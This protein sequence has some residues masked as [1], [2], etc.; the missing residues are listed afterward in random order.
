[1]NLSCQQSPP[2]TTIGKNNLVSDL[3]WVAIKSGINCSISYTYTADYVIVSTQPIEL[4]MI[5]DLSVANLAACMDRVDCKM[6]KA[7]ANATGKAADPINT[8]TGAFSYSNPDMTL[9]TS[10]E[11]LIFQRSYSSGNLAQTSNQL[12]VGWTHNHAARLIFPTD[13][14]GRSGF[15]VFRGVG[16]N[17]HLFVD[18]GNN[19]YSAGPGVT[20]TLVRNSGTP[21]TYSIETSSQS[22]FLFDEAG[23]LISREDENGHAFNYAYDAN[24]NL[25]EVAADAGTRFLSFSYDGQG[26]IVSVVD[27]SNRQVSFGYNASGDLVSYSDVLG[28]T[29]TY[30]YD[31]SHHMTLS[32]PIRIPSYRRITMLTAEPT[33]N[34]TGMGTRL[35]LSRSTVL[36]TRQPLWMR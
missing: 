21:V 35:R 24:D 5:N 26:R 16:G 12:G 10:G 34:L 6:G 17:D 4:S 14:E 19:T 22:S 33:A 9:P 18:N 13:P 23:K 29:W 31:T 3:R 7:P 36:Q 25:T 32:I 1:M 11:E 8:R 30:Q 28:G 15:V 27:Q 2:I 20:A